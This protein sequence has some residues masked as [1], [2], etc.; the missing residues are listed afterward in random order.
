MKFEME[1]QAYAIS[2]IGIS[3]NFSRNDD[4]K[5]YGSISC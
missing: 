4:R 3:A 2:F 5:K 1:K